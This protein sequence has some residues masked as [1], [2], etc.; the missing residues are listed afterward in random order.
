MDTK[1][2]FKD[3][4]KYYP[5]DQV[6]LKAA[7]EMTV[8]NLQYIC[9]NLNSTIMWFKRKQFPLLH[10]Q[11]IDLKNK[12]V[13]EYQKELN[14]PD[15][16]VISNHHNYMDAKYTLEMRRFKAYVDYMNAIETYHK[17]RRDLHHRNE[18]LKYWS[19]HNGNNS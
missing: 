5:A 12:S 3:G 1:V 13:K 15:P 9:Q 18:A 17:S 6:S 7:N 11:Y 10:K 19:K 4:D 2:Y 8:K 16:Q 14:T